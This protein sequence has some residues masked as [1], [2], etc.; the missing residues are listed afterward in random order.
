MPDKLFNITQPIRLTRVTNIEWLNIVYTLTCAQQTIA[1]PN[2]FVFVDLK[3]FALFPAKRVVL[4]QIFTPKPQTF[5]KMSTILLQTP[6][7]SCWHRRGAFGIPFSGRDFHPAHLGT[8]RHKLSM[9]GCS[10]R[11][12]K[13][14]TGWELW[15]KNSHRNGSPDMQC[16]YSIG[17]ILKI[18]N[19][20]ICEQR[21][22]VRSLKLRR[23]HAHSQLYWEFHFGPPHFF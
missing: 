13:L 6:L 7:V 4:N 2:G 17:P 20:L 9:Q 22:S 12:C 14:R 23:K 15:G 5:T 16:N 8:S 10:V 1:T 11:S 3:K 21:S 18:I 19:L